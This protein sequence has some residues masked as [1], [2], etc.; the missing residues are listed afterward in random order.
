[1]NTSF[2]QRNYYIIVKCIYMLVML[3]SFL[4]YMENPIKVIGLQLFVFAVLF[5]QIIL[6]ELVIQHRKW[7]IIIE[8]LLSILLITQFNIN[9]IFLLPIVLLDGISFL[10]LPIYTYLF[11]LVFTIVLP[12]NQAL[13]LLCSAFTDIIYYQNYIIVSEYQDTITLQEEKEYLLKNKMKQEV[14]RNQHNIEN[15][16]LQEREDIY[17]R[18]HDRLG[19]AINGSIYQLE[20]SSVLVKTDPNKSKEMMQNVI[21]ALSSSMDD[22]RIMIRNDRPSKQ[23]LAILQLQQLCDECQNK[24]DIKTTLDIDDDVEIPKST[25]EVIL[26]NSVEAVSNALKYSKCTQIK[27]KI[28]VLPKFIQCSISDNG[29]GCENIQTGMGIQGMKERVKKMNGTIHIKSEVGFEIH[30]IFPFDKEVNK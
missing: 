1:M 24:Y 28:Q 25:W 30:M 17:Q 29:I 7:M 10:Q 9:F 26:D 6:V 13:Y 20:A 27:I 4:F 5:M 11:P 3:A 15:Q 8:L 18:L 16:L 12:S 14:I 22:I 21:L 23:Q 19:H 2:N